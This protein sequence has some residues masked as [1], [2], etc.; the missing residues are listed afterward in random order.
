MKRASC[1]VLAL[2]AATLGA[3]SQNASR[4]SYSDGSQGYVVLVS[5]ANPVYPSLAR[6]ARFTGQVEVAVTVHQDGTTDA[7]V[8]SGH[9]LLTAAALESARQSR[10]ECRECKASFSYS[11]IYSFE[12]GATG[13]GCDGH[14]PQV[15]QSSEQ[16]DSEGRRQTRV[17]ITSG[18]PCIIADPQTTPSRSLKCLYLWK[19]SLK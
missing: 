12:L 2:I 4:T 10:F 5:L 16:I 9:P 3:R 14:S 11:L 15:Q 17:T 18:T 7:V 19:C 13:D 6:V 8:L 1:I